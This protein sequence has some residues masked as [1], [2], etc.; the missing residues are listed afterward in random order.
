MFKRQCN[1]HFCLRQYIG[2]FQ[3]WYWPI[4]VIYILQAKLDPLSICCQCFV[5][6]CQ[7]GKR[8]YSIF[9][10]YIYIYIS[11]RCCYGPL[12][13]QPWGRYHHFKSQK[14]DP[15]IV[16]TTLTPY[17]R[18]CTIRKIANVIYQHKT[19]WKEYIKTRAKRM[20]NSILVKVILSQQSNIQI[21]V[22]SQ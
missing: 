6:R 16:E 17:V 12:F 15:I 1:T 18:L 10:V 19:S 14:N 13:S 20:Y 22:P 9:E 2:L 11:I 8:F 7:E 21:F 5:W 3:A 4:S